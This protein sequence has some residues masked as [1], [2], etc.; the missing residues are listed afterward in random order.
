MLHFNP[1]FLLVCL[2]LTTFSLFCYSKLQDFRAKESSIQKLDSS[3][4]FINHATCKNNSVKKLDERQKILH[5]KGARQKE[6]ER[7]TEM[8]T[9]GRDYF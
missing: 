8:R 7:E 1:R 3:T 5:Q 6:E 2:S 9:G 4:K